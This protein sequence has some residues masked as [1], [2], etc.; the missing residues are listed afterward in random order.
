M[1]VSITKYS[2]KIKKFMLIYGS[3]VL[4]TNF[5]QY[6]QNIKYFHEMNCR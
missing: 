1:T 5:K 3:T 2:K 6:N 4:Q